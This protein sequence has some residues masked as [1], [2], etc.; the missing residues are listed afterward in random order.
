MPMKHIYT[1][2]A[3]VAVALAIGSLSTAAQS[4][5]SPAG[6][7]FLAEQESEIL[8]NA[9]E[10]TLSGQTPAGAS[11]KTM[12]A[13]AGTTDNRVTKVAALVRMKSGVD[14][15]VLV[16]AGYEVT[17][18]LISIAVVNIDIDKLDELAA[19]P[20]VER[21]TFGEKAQLHLEKARAATGVDEAHSGF[22]YN[23]NT[24]KFTGKGVLTGI[25][26]S[27]VAPNH[28][29]FLNADGSTRLKKLFHFYKN[30]DG[31]NTYIIKDF[32]PEGISTFET[33]NNKKAT[34][35]TPSE[36]W[37]ATIRAISQE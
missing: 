21:I 3:M 34:A 30:P 22:E 16:N 5:I 19:M 6:R 4:K 17:S 8:R 2:N 37:P 27:G 7:L 11:L 15:Q 33:D 18:R 25:Y 35:H 13:V 20:E 24:H 1:L 36:S 29:N 23:N 10:I 12:S 26:D 14:P 9:P 32:N 31:S 28:P